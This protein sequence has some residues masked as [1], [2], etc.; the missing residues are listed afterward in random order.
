MEFEDKVPNTTYN[1][2]IGKN[3]AEVFPLSSPQLVKRPVKIKNKYSMM[4][5]NQKKKN[6]LTLDQQQKKYGCEEVSHQQEFIQCKL[7]PTA[8]SS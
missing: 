4:A 6:M 3:E 2:G 7:H 1:C 8:G 5:F